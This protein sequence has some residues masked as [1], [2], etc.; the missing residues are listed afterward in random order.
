MESSNSGLPADV[1][2]VGVRA[3]EHVGGEQTRGEAGVERAAG[4]RL[5]WAHLTPELV[6]PVNPSSFTIY[7]G[8]KFITTYC[9]DP[10]TKPV[11]QNSQYTCALIT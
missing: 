4:R 8:G 5:Q 9:V 3:A 7:S 2:G 1:G 11:E 6:I 10:K